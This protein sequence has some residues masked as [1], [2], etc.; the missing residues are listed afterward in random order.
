MTRLV[1]IGKQVLPLQLQS[2]SVEDGEIIAIEPE[3]PMTYRAPVNFTFKYLDTTFVAKYLEIGQAARIKM[4]GV[5]ATLP[6]AE[7]KADRNRVLALIDI[8]QEDVNNG[9]HIGADDKVTFFA[10]NDMPAPVSAERLMVGIT[11]SL[12]WHKPFLKLLQEQAS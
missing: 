6:P 11:K 7:K 5:V 3:H 2:V 10:E 1:K 12:A 4:T 8:M 9:L